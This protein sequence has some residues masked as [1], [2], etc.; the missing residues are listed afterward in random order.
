MHKRIFTL[1]LACLALVLS[2]CGGSQENMPTTPAATTTLAATTD[3]TPVLTTPQATTEFTASSYSALNFQDMKA[4][5][6]SQYDLSPIY[7]DGDAQRPQADFT[8][9]MAKLLDNVASSGFN[10]VFLQIRPNA[11]S[12][13]P[14]Q[15]YPTSAYVTGQLGREAEYDPVAIIVELAHERSLS[16]HAWINPLRG[17]AE[18]EITLVDS[19]YTIRRWYDSAQVRQKYLAAV[20]GKWYLNP[21]YSDVTDLIVAGAEEALERYAFDGLHMDDY[22]YPTTGPSFD[23][24]AYS[25]FGNGKT[26]ADFRRGNINLLV[27]RLYDVTH[28]SG[29]GRIF[30]ISPAGNHETVYHSQYAD[31]YTWCEKD[32]YVDYI[33]PQVYFG[34]EHGSFDFQKVCKTYSDMIKTENVS[35]IIGMTF[36]KAYTGEDQ[37]AGSGKNEWR[38]HKDVLARCLQTTQGLPHCRGISVFCYQYLFDPLSGAPIPETAK[39]WANFCPVL[40]NITWE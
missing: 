19:R 38:E 35:L 29:Q 23:S 27:R 2:A 4:I 37:W 10:T 20:G 28:A 11:D 17:M 25:A 32:G 34:L 14:S 15:I 8:A 21:A 16:I 5:W 12:M 1:A 3:T 26:L 33:C 18:D 6:L 36:G 40:E 13:Y 22:F 7:L 39:E 9:R 24:L 31:I 30:G